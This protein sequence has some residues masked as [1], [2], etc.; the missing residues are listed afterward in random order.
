MTII[1]KER[2][3]WGSHLHEYQSHR[4]ANWMG[5]DWIEVPPELEQA[6]WDCAGYCDLEIVD[7]VLVGMIPTERP[8][9]PPPPPDPQ[10]DT[11]AIAVD[12]EYRLT[13]LELGV[14]GEV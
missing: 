11:D 1:K 12:H 3:S 8:P 7:G 4:T 6:L 14:T 2:E 5:E 10:E 9:V 13:L